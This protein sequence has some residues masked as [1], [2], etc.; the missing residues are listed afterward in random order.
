MEVL[1]CQRLKMELGFP[2]APL[3]AKTY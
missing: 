2:P 1:E 3:S